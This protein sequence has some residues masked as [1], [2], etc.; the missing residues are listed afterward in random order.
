MP[1]KRPKTFSTIDYIS[2]P[3]AQNINSPFLEMISE[4]DGKQSLKTITE[5]DRIGHIKKTDKLR[6]S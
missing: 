1:L 3:E 2:D 4:I 6:L 5:R